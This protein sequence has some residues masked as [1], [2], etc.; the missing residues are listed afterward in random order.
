MEYVIMLFFKKKNICYPL[1]IK[2][3]TFEGL[4]REKFREKVREKNWKKDAQMFAIP[5]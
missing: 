4:V 1:Q 5:F 2:L 3:K